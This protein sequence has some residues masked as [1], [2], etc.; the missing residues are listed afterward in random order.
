MLPF[1][2]AKWPQIGTETGRYAQIGPGEGK[3]SARVS[4][5]LWDLRPRIPFPDGSTS[6]L[7]PPGNGTLLWVTGHP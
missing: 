2:P 7:T 5:F 1:L 6:H 4:L 3:G